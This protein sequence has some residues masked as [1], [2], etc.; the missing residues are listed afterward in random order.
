MAA[1]SQLNGSNI[2]AR[3]SQLYCSECR[4]KIKEQRETVLTA[5]RRIFAVHLDQIQLNKELCRYLKKQLGKGKNTVEFL[6]E[7]G[8]VSAHNLWVPCHQSAC[9][10][11]FLVVKR[12]EGLEQRCK[13]KERSW[14]DAAINLANIKEEVMEILLD[15]SWWTD[16]LKI[17]TNNVFLGE[18]AKVQTAQ[19]AVRKYETLFEKLQKEGSSLQ[20]AAKADAKDLCS[21]LVGVV[22]WWG[23]RFLGITH[24]PILATYLWS[25]IK[26]DSIAP[27]MEPQLRQHNL[28]WF[29][30]EVHMVKEMRSHG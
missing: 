26:G 13:C 4:Q 25:H 5:I 29:W 21:K 11:L 28:V 7:E 2:D 14:L 18:P 17:A 24:C 6:K 1:T 8:G 19:T 12:V 23:E 22:P 20:K 9:T 15:L 16:V 10:E 3:T 27:D 30:E